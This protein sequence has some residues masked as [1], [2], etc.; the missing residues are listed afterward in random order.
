[1]TQPA[2][3][4]E[5][6]SVRADVVEEDGRFVV[7]LDVVLASGAVRRR[8]SDHPDQ[9]RAQTAATAYA[10]AAGRH[11]GR[12]PLQRPRPDASAGTPGDT[13]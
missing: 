12:A 4:Q 8:L 2:P 10:R 5:A 9:A 13:R 11:L 7:Y 3:V 6:V 1:M